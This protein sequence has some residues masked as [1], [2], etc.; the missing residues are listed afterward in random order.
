[1]R[2]LRCAI[3]REMTDLPDISYVDTKPDEGDSP[4]EAAIR[5]QGS[6]STKVEAV[7]K[8]LLIIKASDPDAKCLIFSTVTRM[9]QF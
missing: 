3:C 9:F 6:H 7:V 1:M 2:R 4:E 8:Q 5:V